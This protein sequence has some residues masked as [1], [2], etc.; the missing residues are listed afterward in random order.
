MRRSLL[1]LA[2]LLATAAVVLS[3]WWVVFP[4]LTAASWPPPT[5][6]STINNSRGHL[7]TPLISRTSGVSWA[8]PLPVRDVLAHNGLLWAATGGGLLVWDV[9]TADHVHFRA[10][11]GLPSHELTTVAADAHGRIWVGSAGAGVAQYDGRAWQIFTTTAGLPS[12]TIHDLALTPAGNLLAGTAAGLAQFDPA[13]QRWQATG[14]TVWQIAPVPIR[15][16][17]PLGPQLWLATPQGI[18]WT[19]G[20][21]WRTFT[22]ADGLPSNDITALAHTAEGVWAGTAAGVAWWDGA[23][24]KP[25]PTLRHPVRALATAADGSLWVG[26]ATGTSQLAQSAAVPVFFPLAG[27][28]FLREVQA[29]V[30]SAEGVWLGTDSGVHWLSATGAS[31][32]L[33]QP[34]APSHATGFY[35]IDG[36]LWLTTAEALYQ[37]DGANWNLIPALHER[38]IHQLTAFGTDSAGGLVAA[39]NTPAQGLL[40]RPR[41][42]DWAERSCVTSAAGRIYGSTV[43]GVRWSASGVGWL[44]AHDG[45]FRL[46]PQGAGWRCD[47][48]TAVGY[49][50][51]SQMAVWGEALY[52]L[53]EGVLWQATASGLAPMMAPPDVWAALTVGQD[54]ALWLA[55]PTALARYD[56]QGQGWRE[57]AMEW[58]LPA[59]AVI[60]QLA[61]QDGLNLWLATDVGLVQY[62]HGRWHWLTT[63]AG[64]PSNDITHLH[65]AT[66]GGVWLATAAGIVRR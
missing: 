28:T 33:A 22:T 50:P 58:P 9:A 5:P 10:E 7:P 48:V 39:F 46:T 57:F 8:N 42:G 32:T 40:Q 20:R 15:T 36:Q 43:R 60:R 63:A 61:V 37:F 44:I 64:L 21:T 3:L 26:N 16:I 52:F 1:L 47:F 30:P 51:P 18:E 65:L 31:H 27:D 66:D 29:I 49:R 14:R 59:T 38:P 24:W 62:V 11:H 17:L 23:T 56:V 35:E 54:G 13:R 6:P 25:I 53:Q 4:L 45:L 55:S 2:I 12:D 34:S 41:G 19:D